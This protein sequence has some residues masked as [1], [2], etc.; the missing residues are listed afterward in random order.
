MCCNSMSWT[1]DNKEADYAAI[2]AENPTNDNE[3]KLTND[4]KKLS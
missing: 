1:S 4:V 2:T 3:E